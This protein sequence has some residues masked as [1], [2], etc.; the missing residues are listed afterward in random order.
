MSWRGSKAGGGVTADDRQSWDWDRLDP[1]ARRQQWGKLASWV[2]WLQ[3]HYESWVKLPPCW[4]R[5]E[6]LR[7]ELA[8]FKGWHEEVMRG[9]DGYD[10]TSWH[11]HLRDAAEAWLAVADCQH[12]DK[13]WRRGS[14]ADPEAVRQ[15]LEIAVRGSAS[16]RDVRDRRTSPPSHQPPPLPSSDRTGRH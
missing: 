16:P 2:A 15:H 5:H 12:E 10:G 14:R 1:V 8:F 6:A 13:P 3:E 11:S 4:P 9:G 7:S